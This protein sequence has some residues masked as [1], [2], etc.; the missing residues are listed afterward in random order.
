MPLIFSKTKQGIV[1]APLERLPLERLHLERS[2]QSYK[3]SSLV[4]Q[5][6]KCK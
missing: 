2:K 5:C 1:K 4:K 3:I 6:N